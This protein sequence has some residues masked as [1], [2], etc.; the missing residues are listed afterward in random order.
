MS[1]LTL[2]ICW[3]F[4]R[5]G[6]FTRSK[7]SK[8]RTPVYDRSTMLSTSIT[9]DKT[10]LLTKQT[11]YSPSELSASTASTFEDNT[12]ADRY[13]HSLIPSRSMNHHQDQNEQIYEQPISERAHHP[14]HQ[15]RSSVHRTQSH[16]PYHVSRNLSYSHTLSD[17]NLI[18]VNDN[19]EI[20]HSYA[21]AKFLTQPK[22]QL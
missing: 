17:G 5:V 9:Y 2:P 15:H 13:H 1:L 19:G 7:T 6:V 10:D 20:I 22:S 3:M 4:H 12:A 21:A 18:K 14:H 8:T 16:T 11:F